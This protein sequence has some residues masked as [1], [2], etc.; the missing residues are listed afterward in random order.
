MPASR[1]RAL[2]TLASALASGDIRLDAGADREEVGARL[3]ALP[4]IGPWTAGYIRMRGLS[5]PDVFLVEDVGVMRALRQLADG[6]PAAWRGAG[7]AAA[8]VP[9]G[10]GAA[11]AVR[12]AAVAGPGVASRWH[13]WRSYAMHHLWATLEQPPASPLAETR[14]AS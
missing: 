14:A 9:T 1:A 6:G 2:V 11:A 8:A 3:V 10:A 4:G 12:A 13:P 7:V 5:D